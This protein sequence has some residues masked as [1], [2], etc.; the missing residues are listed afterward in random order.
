MRGSLSVLSLAGLLIAGCAS[1]TPYV[2]QGPHPQITRGAAIAP[3]DFLGNVL[4]LPGKLI[5][6]NW[7][8]NLHSISSET[9]AKLVE[10][11]DA[12]D[13]P[14]F[15]DTAYKL[16]QY[17]PFADLKALAKNGHVGW[18]YRLLIGLPLTLITDVLLPGRIFPWGDYYNPYSN[19]VHLYSDDAPISLHEAGH[20]YDI[21]DFPLKGTY[22]LIRLVPFIDLYQEWRA[23][24]NAIDYLVETGDREMEDRAYKVLWPAYGTY[25]GG[26]APVP[27]A[28]A[29]GAVL[30]HIAGRGK[31]AARKR[32]YKRMDAILQAPQLTIEAIRKQNA[33]SVQEVIAAPAETGED[34]SSDD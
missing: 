11:L 18:P 6:W 16:N 7:K 13:L 15:E 2:G 32:E 30:G 28:S 21:S 25:L 27:L 1:A 12:R 9:E 29:A 26:Y 3:I 4:S 10:Y 19:T 5:L 33:D 23:T 34:V 20:A 22:A 17:S 8:F 24:D 14:A 31:A